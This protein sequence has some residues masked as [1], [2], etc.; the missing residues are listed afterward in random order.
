MTPIGDCPACGSDGVTSERSGHLELLKCR[1]CGWE[2]CSTVFPNEEIPAIGQSELVRA[3]IRWHGGR[4]TSSEIVAARKVI[5]ALASAPLSR[6]LE[7]TRG[8]AEYDLGVYSRSTAIELQERAKQYG[9]VV[10]L[11]ASAK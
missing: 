7:G 1:H 3:R 11:G 9:L 8:S 4:A 2:L 5:P 6:L 10:L